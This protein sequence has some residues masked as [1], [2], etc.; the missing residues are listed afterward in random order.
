MKYANKQF[1][2]VIDETT[3]LQLTESSKKLYVELKEIE[4]QD[5][6][7]FD[8][9]SLPTFVKVLMLLVFVCISLMLYL[10]YTK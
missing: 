8:I 10:T 1:G 6:Y 7:M 3:Y 4:V 5:D 9:G 2:N